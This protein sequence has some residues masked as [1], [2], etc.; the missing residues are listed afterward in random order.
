[1][2][3]TFEQYKKEVEKET[4]LRLRTDD[5]KVIAARLSKPDSQ[6]IIERSWSNALLVKKDEKDKTDKTVLWAASQAANC[7]CML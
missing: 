5:K 2:A 6:D 3:I 4:A 1:M 7:I